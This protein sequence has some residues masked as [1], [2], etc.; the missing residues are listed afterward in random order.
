MQQQVKW[1]CENYECDSFEDTVERPA[2]LAEVDC[3]D[4]G[5]PLVRED[6][7]EDIS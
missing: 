1:I 5:M 2:E 7:N 4:C 3:P 6:V